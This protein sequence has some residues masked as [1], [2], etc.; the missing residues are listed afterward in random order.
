MQRIGAVAHYRAMLNLL[1]I[2]KKA[3]RTSDYSEME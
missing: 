2:H 3:A 1:N